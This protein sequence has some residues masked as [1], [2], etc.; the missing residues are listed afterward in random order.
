MGKTWIHKFK[1]KIGN[2]DNRV[3]FNFGTKYLKNKAISIRM[4]LFYFQILLS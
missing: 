3:L 4:A 2:F 1:L